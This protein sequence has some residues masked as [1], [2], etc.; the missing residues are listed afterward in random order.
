MKDSQAG[1]VATAKSKSGTTSTFRLVIR[2]EIIP[3]E[4]PRPPV[5]QRLNRRALALVFA[6]VAV[7]TLIWIGISVLRTDPASK[8]AASQGV[9]DVKPQLPARL[10]GPGEAARV[11]SAEPP[12][13]S[14]ASTADAGAA[15]AKS[16]EPRSTEPKSVEP[17]VRDEPDEAPSPVKEVLP[18]VPRSALQTI[19]GTIRVSV[20]VIVDKEGTVIAATPIDP[21]PSRY[22]ERL[23]IGASKKW[24]FAPAHAEAQRTVLVRFNFTREGTTARAN[25]L[26]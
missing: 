14:A 12:P 26:Q 8:P 5:R 21:G 25:P 19:R 3:D 17:K 15:A 13:K 9:R 7:L 22:F 23:A 18:V 16:V 1:S 2:A 20:R 24:T 11:V 10:P 6:A 4:A